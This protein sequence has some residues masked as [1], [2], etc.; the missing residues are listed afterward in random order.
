MCSGERRRSHRA[1]SRV[2]GPGRSGWEAAGVV[3]RGRVPGSGA[4]IARVIA[5]SGGSGG[6]RLSPALHPWD[7]QNTPQEQGTVAGAGEAGFAAQE[8]ALG[9]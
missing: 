7:K 3:G 4:V 1:L 9:D 5:R 8:A 6:T 2:S